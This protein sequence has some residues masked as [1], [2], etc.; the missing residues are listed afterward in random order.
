[1]PHWFASVAC[2]VVGPLFIASGFSKA[3]WPGNTAR[4]AR[5]HDLPPTGVCHSD[6]GTNCYTFNGA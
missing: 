4:A 1:M 2:L 3:F 6:E 5:A